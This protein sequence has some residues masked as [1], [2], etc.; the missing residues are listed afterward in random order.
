MKFQATTSLPASASPRAS[1]AFTLPELMIAIAVFGFVITGVI[2]AN[3]FGL[4]IFQLTETKIT[5]SDAARKALGKMTDDIRNCKTTYV[6]NV[7]TN[8]VFTALAEGVTQ[9]GAGLIIYPTT[10]TSNY[11]VYFLNATD[12]SFRRTT[13]VS[14]STTILAQSITNT[15]L[16]RAQDFRG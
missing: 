11:I 2:A 5:A 15:V 9:S 14:N 12:K 7:S 8:G 6:G 3:L 10:N 16:F 13:S 1:W 4:R